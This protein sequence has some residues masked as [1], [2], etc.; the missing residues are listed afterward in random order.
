MSEQ[1]QAATIAAYFESLNAEDWSRLRSLWHL[2]GEL[3]A[4]GARRRDGREDVMSLFEKLF[5]PWTVHCDKPVRVVQSGTSA[6]VEV[7]FTG[8]TPDGNSVLFEA[9]DVFD[10][11]DGLI[12]RLSNWYD[13]DYARRALESVA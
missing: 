11:E 8:T 7:E 9:V 3:R 13:I 10:F 2:E 6:T 12:R 1:E 4:V 5:N